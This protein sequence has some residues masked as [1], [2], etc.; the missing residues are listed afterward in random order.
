M[1]K[2]NKEKGDVQDLKYL[3]RM[4]DQ[5]DR[6]TK[7]INEPD[8]ARAFKDQ[9]MKE[10]LWVSNQEFKDAFINKSLYK[11]TELEF[12]RLIANHHNYF[13]Y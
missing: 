12:V 3:T 9:I 8:K 2:Y 5:I 13:L 1:E 10:D 6:L 4:S 11:Q 7:I